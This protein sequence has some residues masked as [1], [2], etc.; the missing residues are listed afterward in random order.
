MAT[1]GI[2]FTP[3]P[4]TGNCQPMSHVKVL[5]DGSTIR[6]DGQAHPQAGTWLVAAPS[7]L[8][9]RFIP[10][11]NGWVFAEFLYNGR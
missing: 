10:P 1:S 3:G 9:I 8:A 4:S 7:P 2:G 6:V 11:V 5:C